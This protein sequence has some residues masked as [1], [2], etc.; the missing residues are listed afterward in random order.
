MWCTM[1][2]K[3]KSEK[4]HNFKSATKPTQPYKLKK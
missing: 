4:K 2:A 3:V 1:S